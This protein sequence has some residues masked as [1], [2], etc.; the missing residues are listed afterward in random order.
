MSQGCGSTIRIPMKI[1]RVI[2]PGKSDEEIIALLELEL[3][4]PEEDTDV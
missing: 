3:L 4:E 1:L 2:Y